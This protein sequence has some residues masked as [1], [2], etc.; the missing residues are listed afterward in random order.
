MSF[1]FSK[2]KLDRVLARDE[3]ITKSINEKIRR[4]GI[5]ANAPK[6]K[7]RKSKSKGKHRKGK[8]V[9]STD[10]GE[11]TISNDPTQKVS[12]YSVVNVIS[13]KR[14]PYKKQQPIG[15][16]GAG[17]KKGS[18]GKSGAV[19][20]GL[21]ASASDN[22]QF[23]DPAFGTGDGG[24]RQ[25]LK[26][27][28]SQVDRIEQR[29]NGMG[30]LPAQQNP[31]GPLGNAPAPP[32]QNAPHIN[33]GGGGAGNAPPPPHQHGFNNLFAPPPP[34][35]FSFGAPPR[36]QPPPTPAPRPPEGTPPSR[37][38][39]PT[40]R[41][42]QQEK[43]L[44]RDLNVPVSTI[45]GI[46]DDEFIVLLQARQAQ[47]QAAAS[48]GGGGGGGG[49]VAINNPQG[50]QAAL[51]R[52]RQLK[53][54]GTPRV[55]QL[56][57]QKPVKPQTLGDALAAALGEAPAPAPE[58]QPR[59]PSSLGPKERLQKRE[60]KAQ[61]ALFQ[62]RQASGDSLDLGS[63]ELTPRQ[64]AA[65]DAYLARQAKVKPV[66]RA[67]KAKARA[68]LI[69]GRGDG[70]IFTPS[71]VAPTPLPL[72]PA[73]LSPAVS[74]P[75]TPFAEQFEALEQFVKPINIGE[76][77]GQPAAEIGAS[78]RP[79]V[80]PI[81]GLPLAV[82]KTVKK[83][84][85]L[86]VASPV[87]KSAQNA[88][89]YG[90]FKPDVSPTIKGQEKRGGKSALSQD[91][92]RTENK[93]FKISVQLRNQFGVPDNFFMSSKGK[94]KVFRTGASGDEVLL[95]T[96]ML[97]ELRKWGKGN[98]T[99]E[100]QRF[101]NDKVDEFNTS[102]KEGLK[103]KKTDEKLFKAKALED[104][105]TKKA[106]TPLYNISESLDKD[107]AVTGQPEAELGVS[108]VLVEPTETIPLPSN[109]NPDSA[110]VGAV[111]SAAAGAVVGGAASLAGGIVSGAA[112][113]IASQ[114]PS[115]GQ[116]G[117]AL[118]QGA[119][120]GAGVLVRGSAGAISGGYQMLNPEYA[121]PPGSPDSPDI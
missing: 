99:A 121:S 54:R 15:P 93:K 64:Q 69:S 70:A 39:T 81:S 14:G 25:E 110:G 72:P 1:Y 91:F 67:N 9:K 112:S 34:G 92:Y 76:E 116:V 102:H 85:G 23:K 41:T 59:K 65:E 75:G 111:A 29:L 100:Q 30:N 56:S 13:A 97:S 94:P 40:P 42:R 2:N 21:T 113:A 119:V 50:A 89:R 82:G 26:G 84:S 63:P 12:G 115:A 118:G 78:P 20:T 16:P 62:G 57:Q 3:V 87:N 96:T 10:K 55:K 47:L 101:L 68:A 80:S 83:G 73:D 60:E 32:Q 103:I 88:G 4:K 105:K 19:R 79:V 109:T 17:N 7:K 120:I 114:L 11:I 71:V 36:Y 77:V 53:A 5:S 18:F 38:Q 46:S 28:R 108:G 95:S 37:P 86:P 107:P 58:T 35:G 24:T 8:K 48:V 33:P 6:K 31:A 117:T 98:L 45:R 90:S 51:E 52:E 61:D 49:G 66:G 43:L 74:I 27:L 104:L 106:A 44:A 22:I